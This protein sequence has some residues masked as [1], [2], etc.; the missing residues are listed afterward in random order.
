MAV[1]EA[2]VRTAHVVWDWNGTLFDD[3]DALIQ[4][5][6]EA[7]EVIGAP[8]VT[9]EQYREQHTQPIDVFYDRLFGAPV[10]PDVRSALHA[11]FHEAYSRRR[12]SLS[13][14]VDA[15]EVLGAIAARGLSQSLLSMHPHDRLT[16]LVDRFGITAHFARIDGQRGPDRGFK[17]AHLAEHLAELG[18]TAG[19]ALLIGDSVDDAV[20][21]KALGMRCVLYASGLHATEVLAEQGVPVVTSLREAIRLAIGEA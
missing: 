20:A 8:P 21:A 4:S 13:L 1:N 2:G 15:R 11:A 3:A 16:T 5:T 19:D 9:V 14:A 18:L 12:P 6:I 7:F 10:P 17:R